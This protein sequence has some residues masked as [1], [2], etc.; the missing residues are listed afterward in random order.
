[1]Y[2]LSEAE[3]RACARGWEFHACSNSDLGEPT[4]LSERK[5][6]KLSREYLQFSSVKFLQILQSGN[7][8]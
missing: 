6:A 7:F 2:T 4:V 8:C 3:V 5:N 1:M